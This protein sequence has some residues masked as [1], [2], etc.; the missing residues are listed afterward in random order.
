MTI[1]KICN[2]CGAKNNEEAKFCYKCAADIKDIE[3][4]K[5]I[6]LADDEK[7]CPNCKAINNIEAKFCK[8]CAKS[9]SA[10]AQIEQEPVITETAEIVDIP[11][12]N[13]QPA[14]KPKKNV[15][16]PVLIGIIA[17][18]LIAVAVVIVKGNKKPSAPAKPNTTVSTTAN[19]TAEN[20][21]KETTTAPTTQNTT[22]TE[23]PSQNEYSKILPN[24]IW[25]YY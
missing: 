6:V 20:T 21:T 11:N 17:V 19:T 12:E 1:S 8:N 18:V 24:T 9:F 4:K 14:V 16:M 15:P 2:N 22:T 23:A 13:I 5:E 10:E 3:P 25:R 7:Q